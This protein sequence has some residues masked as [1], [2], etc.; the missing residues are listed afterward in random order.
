MKAVFTGQLCSQQ[1][2]SGLQS[3]T[4]CTQQQSSKAQQDPVKV[5]VAVR[6]IGHGNLSRS[7]I[8]DGNYHQYWW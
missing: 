8:L 3:L 4:H 1:G 5:Q 2:L 6:D 7:R